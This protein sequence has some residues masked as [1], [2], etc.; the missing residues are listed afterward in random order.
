MRRA[1]EWDDMTENTSE[2]PAAIN[3]SY[4]LQ[5]AFTDALAIQTANRIY[6][7]NILLSPVYQ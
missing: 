4:L 2:V 1:L 6:T 5:A 3:W 7:G